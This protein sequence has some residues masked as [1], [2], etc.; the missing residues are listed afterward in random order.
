MLTH[1]TSFSNFTL[2]FVIGIALVLLFPSILGSGAFEKKS[3]K[4]FFFIFHFLHEFIIAS[5]T[6]AKMVL[7]I[8]LKKIQCSYLEIS[9]K[10]LSTGETLFFGHIVTLTPGTIT[11]DINTQN[12]VMTIHAMYTEQTQQIIEEIESKIKRPMMEFL[13]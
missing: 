4:S 1:D 7:F 3:K 5:L 2:G 10:P 12:N 11:V 6:V 9:T 13:R 8:P